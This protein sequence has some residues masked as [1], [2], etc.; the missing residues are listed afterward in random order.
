MVA[1]G[2]VGAEATV[3]DDD[4][5]LAD[6]VD[7]E[8]LERGR[9]GTSA[10]G[11]G[12]GVDDA[13]LGLGQ[14][15]QLLLGL[16]RAGVGALLEVGPVA[17]VLRR[18]LLAVLARADDPR[19]RQEL[20]RVV[21]RQRVELH[22][23]EQAGRARLGRL[24]RSVGQ[25]L[26]DVGAVASVAGH[27]VEPGLRVRAEVLLLARGVL[28]QLASRVERELV[29]R[30][31]LGHVGA[32]GHLGASVAGHHGRPLDVGPV[33]ADAHRDALTELEGGQA[34]G[35]DV[36][37]VLDE[38]LEA[39]VALVVAGP[40]ALQH[41]QAVLAPV[42]DLVEH[43]LEL[44]RE[45]VVDQPAEVLLHEP[46]DAEGDPRRDQR[47]ALLVDVPAVLDRVDDR[48]VGGGAT[49]L[50][51]LELLDQAGLGVARGRLGLVAAGDELVRQDRVAL[52]E[53][54]E[55]GLLVVALGRRVLVGLD[56][57]L[58]EPVERD[59]AAGCREL[60]RAAVG[61]VAGQPDR[62]LFALR[63][64]HLRG[65]RALPDQL[66]E[67][68]LVA[69]EAGLLRRAE[70]L[71]RRTDGLVGLLR[72]LG[73]AGV[74]ARL[75]GQ[76]GRAVQLADLRTGRVERGLAQRRGV[77]THVGDV[78]ALVEPLRDLHRASGAPAELAGGLLLHRRGAERGVGLA[79]VRLG[80]D[81]RDRERAATKSFG[82]GRDGGLV[83]LHD[84]GVL[85]LAV[86]AEGRS[87]GDALALDRHEAGR[88]E[89][90]V[91]L[92][93]GVERGVEVPVRGGAERDALPLALDHQTGGDGLD[94]TGREAA[95]DL[96][97]Q[98]RADLVAVQ[99]VEDAA[100]LLRVD[101]VHVDVTRVGD[102]A[103]DRLLGDLVEHDALDRDV[104]LELVEQVP[105]DGLALAVLIRREHE[106]VGVLE[107]LLEL[108]DL[109][110]L[111]GRDH[112]D[113]LEVVVDVDP[114]AC[115]RQT[116]VLGRDLVGA[117]REV[118]DVTDRGVHDV[119]V[120]EVARNAADL[121]RRLDDHEAG[122]GGILSTAG[123]GGNP[124]RTP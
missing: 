6:G 65:D 55:L 5:L 115:P 17:A 100:G 54:G 84:L 88:E 13:G 41:A 62:E 92:L 91:V 89:L 78:A 108:G 39:G 98:H 110:L 83:E 25:R 68:R 30:E 52:G 76:V 112:V 32:G 49:D 99:A 64:L 71:A 96:L 51:L 58:E 26:H 80:L 87:G 12:L 16:D 94:T 117:L 34:P 24:G 28:Q 2:D 75:V 38:L 86:G 21:E 59:R 7:A 3:L 93:V 118:T 14:R 69:G 81:R 60:D 29:G 63:V 1:V 104:G 70:L 43:A 42:R 45:G 77:G 19:E 36:R 50:A 8:L 35:V 53:V 97:P 46:H 23:L 10:V 114:E 124:A 47:G 11:L 48:G 9:G 27:D 121:V 107:E 40:E 122:H 20:D 73:R 66:V 15:E 61:C 82:E 123:N 105:G 101:E 116:L 37:Q 113:R 44:G 79:R 4:R 74:D 67:L 111:A 72:V 31:V 119:A 103:L 120:A 102:R 90:R 109:R 22:R 106:L 33:P 57:R 18:D 95:H 56:V 85:E